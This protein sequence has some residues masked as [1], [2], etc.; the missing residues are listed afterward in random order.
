MKKLAILSMTFLFT[1]SLVQGQTKQA[2]KKNINETKKELKTERVAL[3]KLEGTNVSTLAKKSF[4]SDFVN[5][6]DAKWMRLGTFDEVSFTKAGQK[7]KAFYDY[8]GNL[9]GTTSVKT[10]ADLP[11][12]G[13]QE[14]KTKYKDYSVGPVIL[15]D[16][17]EVNQTDMILWDTQ[18]D[19]EDNYF[20]ELTKG[21][22]T[23]ILQVN[24][25][26][27]VSYFKQL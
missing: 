17:N 5:V 13:Q 14:I 10:F 24:L 26:G 3:K 21:G 20:V 15:Y 6:S 8:D 7:M 9:V 1:L 4:D 23:L 22:K 12:K 19:D 2:D 16:D 11:A 27:D 25:N 18:F